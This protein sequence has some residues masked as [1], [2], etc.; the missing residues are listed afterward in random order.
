MG[1]VSSSSTVTVQA[2][3]TA[4]GRKKLFDSL[5]TVNEPFITKFALGDSDTNY[6]AVDAGY[7]ALPT[8]L[9]PQPGEW[10]PQ[11]RSFLL[12]QGS[13][14]PSVAH[15]IVDGR[16]GGAEG[17]YRTFPIGANV[18][19][20]QKYKIETEWP[21]G[22]RYAEE[23][24]VSYNL[25]GTTGGLSDAALFNELFDITFVANEQQSAGDS[26]TSV[27]ELWLTFRGGMDQSM[28]NAIIG[29]DEETNNGWT[30]E[31]RIEG[32]DSQT[33][34]VLTIDFVK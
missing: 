10:K 9:V 15:V 6:A 32:L 11:I 31:A 16:Y 30:L 5:E 3:L 27:G 19:N 24:K 7:G 12:A 18:A 25:A 33:V 17:H 20:Q 29:A 28:L 23:Y 22:T 2:F 21:K 34:T 1:F 14:K 13:Y 26:R 4:A 8:G